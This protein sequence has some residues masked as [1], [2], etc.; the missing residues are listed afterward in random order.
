M[1]NNNLKSRSLVT[2]QELAQLQNQSKSG[3]SWFY[4]IAALSLVNTIIVLLGGDWSFILGLAITQIVDALAT[5]L[6][7][8]VGGTI[9]IVIR[10][11]SVVL[12]L[13]I[14][15]LFYLF[16]LLAHKK[17]KWSFIIGMVLYVLDGLLFLL[18]KDWLAMGFHL[19]ALFF[20]YQGLRAL[21]RLNELE[22]ASEGKGIV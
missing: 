4:W 6:R 22:T 16:G 1:Q 3:A 21:L 7:E 10:I 17:Y 5:V 13:L 18:L 20:L 2:A 14:A 8:Q 12:D 15:G 19:L 9:G 11:I